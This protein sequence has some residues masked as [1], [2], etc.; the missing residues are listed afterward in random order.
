[1]VAVLYE[2]GTAERVVG[3]HE[4]H[5]D[6]RFA[7]SLLDPGGKPCGSRQ[8]RQIP[9]SRTPYPW[10]DRL[11]YRPQAQKL[12]HTIALE[13]GPNFGCECRPFAIH[14]RPSGSGLQFLVQIFAVQLRWLPSGGWTPPDQNLG[15]FLRG[16]VLDRK[17]VV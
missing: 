8:V 2:H 13:R 14:A 5:A 6:R 15:E 12:V 16:L 1:M 11:G 17:S 7:Q 9:A 3:I 10:V 4:R